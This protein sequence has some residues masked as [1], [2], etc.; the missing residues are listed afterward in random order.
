MRRRVLGAAVVALFMGGCATTGPAAP[1]GPAP[2]NP[3]D[4]AWLQLV[5]PM[6]ENAVAAARL[7][8]DHTQNPAI[9][10]AASAF[11]GSQEKLLVRLR[12]TRDRA[13]LPAADV[14]SGHKM[15]GMVTPADLVALRT[16]Q[17]AGFDQRLVGL[18]RAHASQL[19]VLSRGEQASGADAETREL[20]REAG[21]EGTHESELLAKAA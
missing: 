13:G 19:V 1:A 3:T 20:A 10:A 16:D 17:G 6:T 7:A 21:A 5:V 14:H 4:V 2:F 18:L 9:T 8:P 15:P 12:A 11:A